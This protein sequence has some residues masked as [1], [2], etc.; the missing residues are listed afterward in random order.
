MQGYFESLI[1]SVLTCCARSS[2]VEKLLF[3]KFGKKNNLSTTKNRNNFIII[4]SH[5]DLPI[6]ILRKPSMYKSSTRF[7][8]FIQR[9]YI[10]MKYDILQVVGYTIFQR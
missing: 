5:N 1:N 7:N 4:S 3:R 2:S 8:M 6:V 10:K 9:G